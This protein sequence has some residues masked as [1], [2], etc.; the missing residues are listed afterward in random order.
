MNIKRTKKQNSAKLS[1]NDRKEFTWRK[2]LIVTGGCGVLLIVIVCVIIFNSF[3]S[4]S[5]LTKK[6]AQS[7]MDDAVNQTLDLMEDENLLYNSLSKN[8]SITVVSIDRSREGYQGNCII[9][10]IDCAGVLIEYLSNIPADEIALGSEILVRL[11]SVIEAA[12]IIQKEFTIEFV[13][14]DDGYSPIFTEEIVDYCSGNIQAVKV[15]LTQL[16]EQEDLQ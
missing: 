4:E 13:K 5:I 1:P 12:P 15:Y 3:N 8:L 14:T 2:W 6:K 16:I 7:I 10:S 11:G 9:T